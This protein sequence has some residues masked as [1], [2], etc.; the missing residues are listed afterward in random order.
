MEVRK[1]KNWKAIADQIKYVKPYPFALRDGIEVIMNIPTVSH[2]YDDKI[3]EIRYDNDI[4][5]EFFTK[6]LK[7]HV[8]S[9]PERVCFPRTCYKLNEL[10]NKAFSANDKEKFL[11]QMIKTLPE[12]DEILPNPIKENNK[13]SYNKWW[14]INKRK[15]KIRI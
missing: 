11:E 14:L 4:D 5:M 6:V 10:M 8:L 9:K 15:S 13:P 1:L 12:S 7:Q 3:P 2:F